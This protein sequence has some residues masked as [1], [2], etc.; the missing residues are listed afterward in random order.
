MAGISE[1]PQG[2]ALRLV[3][4]AAV[5]LIVLRDSLLEDP[6]RLLCAAVASVLVVEWVG[7]GRRWYGW[8]CA[9]GLAK[10]CA[11]T[12]RAF[13][14]DRRGFGDDHD[15]LWGLLPVPAVPVAGMDALLVCIAAPLC[16]L[17]RSQAA[18]VLAAGA[19]HIFVAN[20]QTHKTGGQHGILVLHVLALQALRSEGEGALCLLCTRAVVLSLYFGA[21]LSKLKVSGPRWCDGGT[22]QKELY[23]SAFLVPGAPWQLRATRAVARDRAL[24]RFASTATVVAELAPLLMLVPGARA[25][26]FE[27]LYVP[28]HVAIYVLMGVDFVTWWVPVLL[29][30][31]LFAREPPSASLSSSPAMPLYA[32]VQLVISLASADLRGVK[33]FPFTCC[34]MFCDRKELFGEGGGTWTLTD[35]P[36]P[37]LLTPWYPP[38]YVQGKFTAGELPRLPYR[39]ASFSFG[40][41]DA[42]ALT[43]L[44]PK[45]ERPRDGHETFANFEVTGCLRDRLRDG[46]AFVRRGDAGWAWD[47]GRMDELLAHQSAIQD[48]M[49]AACAGEDA[50]A[51][52]PPPSNPGG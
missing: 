42:L 1:D 4:A 39:Y 28:V 31:G 10:Y 43:R 49:R 35:A 2:P 27:W 23:E 5:I 3:L 44:R 24:C 40:A 13:P 33:C 38:S 14:C 15:R 8:L 48:A 6:N 45:R 11:A 19:A 21:A 25:F 9:S 47:R 17:P 18:R 30:L 16:F 22:L 32:L 7:C 26:P 12:R 51:V 20:L 52:R 36:L 41:G 50:D 34:P 37:G 46:A 29:L